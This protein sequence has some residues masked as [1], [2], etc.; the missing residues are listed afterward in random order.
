MEIL[1]GAGIFLILWGMAGDDRDKLI[2]GVGF[3][4]VGGIWELIQ[5]L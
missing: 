4:I 5:A 1:I 3:I 2:L